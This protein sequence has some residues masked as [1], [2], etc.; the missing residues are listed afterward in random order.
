MALIAEVDF[1]FSVQSPWD[2]K[3]ESRMGCQVAPSM[4]LR[5]FRAD[6]SNRKYF[7]CELCFFD[8]LKVW[9][10]RWYAW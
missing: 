5:T 10:E 9:R 2:S 6:K 4:W 8:T 3:C 7:Y 1:G